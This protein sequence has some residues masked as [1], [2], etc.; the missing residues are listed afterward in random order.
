MNFYEFVSDE[1]AS[2]SIQHHFDGFFLNKIPLMRKLKWREVVGAK[3][4]IGRVSPNNKTL[5]L[6]PNHLYELNRGPFFEANIGIENIFKIFRLDGVYR[7]SY[8][9]NPRVTPF[10]IRFSF[11]FSF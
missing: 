4:L 2:A 8:L 9:D 5:L 6:F 11:Q 3:A 10:S 7:L 1:Y